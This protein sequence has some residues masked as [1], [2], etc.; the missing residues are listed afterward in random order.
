MA[1]HFECKFH[2]SVLS[3][4]KFLTFMNTT[5]FTKFHCLNSDFEVYFPSL[6]SSLL[7]VQ[8]HNQTIIKVRNYLFFKL[9]I[10]VESQEN[11]PQYL[12][13]VNEAR[14]ITAVD[15]GRQHKQL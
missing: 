8:T 12:S 3:Q 11:I 15:A 14:N 6:Y 1:S 10:L 4:L 13:P 2:S 9:R 5:D 7:R